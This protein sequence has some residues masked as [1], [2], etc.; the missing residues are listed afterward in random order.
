[1]PHGSGK[2]ADV[3]AGA[4]KAGKSKDPLTFESIFDSLLYAL[5][6]SYSPTHTEMSLVNSLTFKDS[7]N[8][9]L[10]IQERRHNKRRKKETMR[11][12]QGKNK[13]GDGWMNNKRMKE[14]PSLPSPSGLIYFPA[15]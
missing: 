12:E 1:M 13:T 9:V 6:C 2:A 3:P 5:V 8:V 14:A 15:P 7:L 4:Q 11:G 10:G